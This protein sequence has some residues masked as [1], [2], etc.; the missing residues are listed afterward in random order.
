MDYYLRS[1]AY[2]LV[3]LF[4]HSCSQSS[5]S[6]IPPEYIGY[7]V[8]TTIVQRTEL[9]SVVNE[10]SGVISWNDKLWMHN[11]SKKQASIFCVDPSNGKVVRTVYIT[12]KENI[13][14]ED[15]T[16]DDTYIYIGDYGNNHGNRKDLGIYK[17]LKSDIEAGI[18]SVQS[19]G[20][21][22]FSYPDQTDF[23]GPTHGHDY[24]CEGMIAVGDSLYLFS[25][26]F[27]DRHSRLYALPKSSGTHVANLQDRF[28]VK[29]NITGAG[30]NKET[31]EVVL[32]GYF[33]DDGTFLPFAWMFW[34]YS[35]QSFFRGKSK[36]VNFDFHAQIEGV[37][38][39]SNGQC[40]ICSEST[41]TSNGRLYEFFSPH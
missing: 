7:V 5:S 22:L 10:C 30:I 40:Y 25:K 36:R 3:I 19:V 9:S 21:I 8:D 35:G 15:I 27:A 1:V 26:N 37:G 4:F 34:D 28:D 18:D 29:G 23:S 13:D 24:D 12:D 38:Y 14:W 11:D 41:M 32:S 2:L 16:Q 6:D 31:G 39:S 33:Y 20:T 17:I